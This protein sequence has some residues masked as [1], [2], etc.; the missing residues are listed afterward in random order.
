MDLT[1]ALLSEI[2]EYIDEG[3]YD[4]AS[5]KISVISYGNFKKHNS[6]YYEKLRYSLLDEI[7]IAQYG[8]VIIDD[9]PV[10][11]SAKSAVG[12]NCFDVSSIFEKAGFRNVET[13]RGAKAGA[14]HTAYTVKE[15]SI[16]GDTKFDSSAIF[17]EDAVIVI[18]YYYYY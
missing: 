15:I 12:S 14:F 7:E 18:F 16:N 8:K 1:N 10:P 9:I 5:E 17:P 4:A 2:R 3:E 11:M 6:D 13:V